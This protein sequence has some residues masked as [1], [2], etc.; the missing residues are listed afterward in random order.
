MDAVPRPAG[1][2]RVRRSPVLVGRGAELATA[3]GLVDAV[4][5]G[6]GGAL[7]VAGE[8]GIGKTRVL[9]EV[10]E[11]AAGRGLPVLSGRAVQ[12]GGTFRAVAGAV[13]G[14]LDDPARAAVALLLRLARRDAARGALRSAERLL[15]T[16]AGA[17]TAPAPAVIA[18]QVTVLTLVGRSADALALGAAELDGLHGD[19]HAELCLQLARTAVAAGAWADAEAYVARAGRPG[20]PRSLVLRADAAFGAGR[21]TDAGEFAAAAI[22]R[23]EEVAD[24]HLARGASGTDEG[25]VQAAG[26]LCEALGVAARLAWGTDLDVT[27]ALARRAAQVAG[28]HGLVPWRVT[29][30]FQLGMMATLRAHDTAPLLQARELALDAGMLGQVAA[31][32]YVRADYTWWADGPAAALP[33]AHAAHA[34]TRVLHLPSRAFNTRSMVEI[35]EAAAELVAGTATPSEARRRAAGISTQGGSGP[36]LDQVLRI[37][38]ALVEHDLPRAADE[39]AAGGR[40]LLEHDAVLPPLP[41][42]GASALVHAAVGREDAGAQRTLAVTQVPANRGVFAWADAITHGRAGRRQKAA[43]LLADGEEAL[44]GLPWW[45]R[46]LHTVV[47]DSAVGDGWGDPVPT[48]RADLAVHEQRGDVLLA[49]TCRDLLRRAGAPAPRSRG[50]TAVS[51]RLRA[52]GITAREAEVLGLVAEGLTNVQ[53]AERLFLSP[54]TVDTHVANLLAKAGVPSRT[55]LRA[56]AGES[57]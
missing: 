2:G 48:L 38:I 26:A 9:D 49:R 14:L 23:A 6:R 10:A 28:E 11:R 7:L 29:A 51:P 56:W 55:Q 37:V 17:G 44:A 43:A 13:I 45:R 25:A 40:H 8:A 42:V 15:A 19:A 21:A 16:A 47:L 50:G 20:D 52:R 22:A 30:L 31:I 35:L 57:R 32:D 39:L 53:V 3:R 34:L 12:G 4:A 24:E 46:L 41:Y 54:R 1:P 5:A 36:R 18:E 33:S 27:E